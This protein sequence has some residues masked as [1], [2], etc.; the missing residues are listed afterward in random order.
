MPLTDEQV[1]IAVS[2]AK[3][4]LSESD[5]AELKVDLNKIIESIEVLNEFDLSGVEPTYHPLAD[6]Q[7]VMREDVIQPSMPQSVALANAATHEDGQFKVP[8]IL[9]DGGGDQ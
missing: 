2:E 3:F 7:N 1:S 4:A 5:L 8:T 9:V 6:L